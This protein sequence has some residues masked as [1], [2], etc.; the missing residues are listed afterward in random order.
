MALLCACE[1][2]NIL[3]MCSLWGMLDDYEKSLC[4]IDDLINALGLKV[5]DVIVTISQEITRMAKIESDLLV[6]MN[7]KQLMSNVIRLGCRPLKDSFQFARMALSTVKIVPVAGNSMQVN[8]GGNIDAREQK[9]IVNN[10][11]I[12]SIEEVTRSL[13]ESKPLPGPKQLGE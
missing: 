9:Q 4:N 6:S 2:E 10:T 11:V 5:G 1:D 12:P 13:E 3:Q 8:I 7:A